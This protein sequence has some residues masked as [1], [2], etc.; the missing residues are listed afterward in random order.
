VSAAASGRIAIATQPR[1]A[2]VTRDP[3]LA[4]RERMEMLEQ[5]GLTGIR[6][7]TLP[8]DPPVVCVIGV[9]QTAAGSGD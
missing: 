3:V 6:S 1:G 7:D 8:L 2:D 9:K 4:A 5:T